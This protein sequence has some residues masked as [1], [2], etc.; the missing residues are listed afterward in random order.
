MN[1]NVIITIQIIIGLDI[2]KYFI[3]K[4]VVKPRNRLPREVISA[5]NLSYFKSHL[6]NVLNICF[7]FWLKW[8]EVVKQLE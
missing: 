6:V 5:P 8:P 1:F 7:H 3:T 4:K 2:R